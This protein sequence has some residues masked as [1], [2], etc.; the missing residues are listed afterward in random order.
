MAKKAVAS[1]TFSAIRLSVVG[2]AQI[3]SAVY[4]VLESI[5]FEAE[6]QCR[7]NELW[8][9]LLINYQSVES[10]ESESIFGNDNG[11]VAESESEKEIA[12]VKP[13]LALITIGNCQPRSNLLWTGPYLRGKKRKV[14]CK[15]SN[16]FCVSQ[17]FLFV[18]VCSSR[19]AVLKHQ[20]IRLQLCCVMF[21]S[22]PK[23]AIKSLIGG[24]LLHIT[25]GT[26]YCAPLMWLST[27]PNKERFSS[28]FYCWGVWSW[29][30]DL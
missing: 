20:G 1:P 29:Q 8:A 11:G 2:N 10:P 19:A 18:F 24:V 4:R 26:L 15:M 30:F 17:L 7:R 25:F 16:S 5:L 14:V 21:S 23:P 6:K 28:R 13:D 27:P 12:A 9:Q 3:L 22:I